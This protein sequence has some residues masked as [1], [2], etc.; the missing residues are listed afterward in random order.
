MFGRI[1]ETA[2]KSTG[3]RASVANAVLRRTSVRW[4]LE[5]TVGITRHRSMP[6][7]AKVPFTKWF[8]ARDWKRG[9]AGQVVLFNDT[10]NTYNYPSVAMA[11]TELLEA[12]GYEVI[13][14]GHRCCGR[15]MLSKGML[16]E[17]RVLA[18][19]TLDALFAYAEEDIPILGLEPSCYLSFD[20]EYRSLFPG[21]RRVDTVVSATQSFEAFITGLAAGGKLPLSFTGEDRNVV[22]HG[23]CHLKSLAG[24][25]TVLGAL[26]LPE[27]YAVEEITSGC[28]GMAG[29]FGFE[30]EHYDISVQIGEDR[31]FP[32]VRDADDRTL[33]CA[34]GV[35]C[36][37]QIEHGTGRSVLHPAELLRGALA[38]GGAKASA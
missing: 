9:T 10:F 1:A 7:F 14:P 35:S 5:K 17:A 3:L 20:D 19:E 18:D 4:T 29:S 22:Y 28:C 24:T 26:R 34:S 21:D 38:S 23:H 8:A 15:P 12:C 36:R 31:L 2:R 13:L 6:P 37:Q 25:S 30:K 33:V 16:E 27:N 11:A 32:A